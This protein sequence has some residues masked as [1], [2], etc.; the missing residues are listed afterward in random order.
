MGYYLGIDG[1][2][3][4]TIFALADEKGCLIASWRG[5]S[6]SYKQ[7]G[8]EGV[9]RIFTPGAGNQC[10]CRDGIHRLWKKQSR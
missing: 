3:S 10:G 2:G 5:G 7:I 4:K 9:G 8:I 6:A 1:G